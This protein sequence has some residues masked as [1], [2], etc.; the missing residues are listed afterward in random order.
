M[1]LLFGFYSELLND[2]TTALD[3]R[4]FVGS[5]ERGLQSLVQSLVLN[6]KSVNFYHVQCYVYKCPL[7]ISFKYSVCLKILIKFWDKII[8]FEDIL[9]PEKTNKYTNKQTVNRALNCI[10][11]IELSITFKLV[12]L[13][14][15]FSTL[16]GFTSW[17]SETCY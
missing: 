4:A 2:V 13:D 16:L 5:G 6:R 3:C 7:Y 9:P 10:G 14:P 1:L 12:V 15:P 8:L 17:I 11:K